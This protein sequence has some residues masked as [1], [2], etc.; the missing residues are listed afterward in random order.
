MTQE[1]VSNSMGNGSR[2]KLMEQVILRLDQF[3]ELQGK[4]VSFLILIATLQISY[5]LVL[6]YVFNAPTVWG[7]EMT[8]YLCGVTYVMSGAFAERYGAH[9]R[10]D[11][12][13]NKWKLR[14][15]AWFD[16]LVTDL[17]FFFF[18]G[19]LLWF[20]GVWFWEAATQGLTSGTIW[21]PPIWP[22][23]LVIVIGALFLMISGIPKVLRDLAMALWNVKL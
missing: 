11:V 5:E 19:V 16:L 1:Q 15:R 9:I 13:Y 12:F 6:R 18:G 10:V 23:R 17:L 14:T 20:S 8:V 2:Y 3:S 21:D 22:M 7:L 4:A